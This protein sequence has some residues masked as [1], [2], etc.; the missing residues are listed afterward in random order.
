MTTQPTLW[1]QQ[2]H[3]ALEQLKEIPL[4]GSAP[5]FPWELLAERLSDEL[6]LREVEIRS[7]NTHYLT[8]E[9]T[10]SG[11]GEDPH[12]L[13]LSL[14]PLPGEVFWIFPRKD[15]VALMSLMTSEDGK[16]LSSEARAEG[17]YTFSA[18]K[19]LATI[20]EIH[21]LED[22]RA[23]LS[24][25]AELPEEGGFAIDISVSVLGHTFW[26]R[27]LLSS[28]THSAFI[29][30]FAA[31]SSLQFTEKTKATPVSLTLEIG[32]TTLR[33]NQV[34]AIAAGDFVLLDRC[35]YDPV[36]G[37]G[38]AAL[39]LGSTPLF[40]I[41]LKG[42]EAKLLEYALFQE[43][44]AMTD[45]DIPLPPSDMMKKPPSPENNEEETPLW[46]AKNGEN[47]EVKE[48]I[49]KSSIPMHLTVEVGKIQM[50]LEKVLQLEPG[51][52]LEIGMNPGLGVY[53]TA[54]GKRIA[55]G[56][57]V[58][59]GENLGVKVLSVGK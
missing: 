31:T 2:L 29:N 55:K 15:L 22:L 32:S 14:T 35:T 47:G 20:N 59:I 48:L 25:P 45:D 5:P 3:T 1:I 7:K 6:G 16:S 38:T 43:E 58:K 24:T 56:E 12:I 9:K 37:R 17:F 50:P 23:S 51:N 21:A 33:Q 13:T 36:A 53:L 10:P 30:H 27:L 49:G 41:R 8:G 19:A 46:S 40:D 52:V 44:E 4:W 26:G 28:L 42:G 39:V 54:G 57:L 11:L 34:T 18:L